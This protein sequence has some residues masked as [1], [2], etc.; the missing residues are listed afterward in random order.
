[1]AD[2]PLNLE[3]SKEKMTSHEVDGLEVDSDGQ[4]SMFDLDAV[5]DNATWEELFK[6]L[7]QAT[8]DTIKENF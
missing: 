7:S 8:K 4:N 1:M 5:D 2:K 6:G 3:P